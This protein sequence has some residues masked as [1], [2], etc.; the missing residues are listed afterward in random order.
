[1]DPPLPTDFDPYRLVDDQMQEP[2]KSSDKRNNGE[3]PPHDEPQRESKMLPL[4]KVLPDWLR[5][6]VFTGSCCGSVVFLWVITSWDHNWIPGIPS[7]FAM[8]YDQETK[9]IAEQIRR[10]S[11]A[12]CLSM[13]AEAAFAVD[14]QLEALQLQ[15]LQRT[16]AR[17]PVKACARSDKR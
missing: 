10:L 16:G 7:Q 1:M 15:Y 13:S 3:D 5:R 9:E 12:R 2:A 4:H 11:P 6:A 17:Y 14:E 8:A